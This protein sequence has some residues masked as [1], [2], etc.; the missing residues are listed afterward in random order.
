MTKKCT[1]CLQVLDIEKFKK[2]TDG[3]REYRARCKD[4]INQYSRMKLYEKK[5]EKEN[6]FKE[7]GII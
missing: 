4:C 7:F 2:K 6:Y 3:T 5:Q 1:G